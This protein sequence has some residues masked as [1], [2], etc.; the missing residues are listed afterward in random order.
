MTRSREAEI[1][2]LGAATDAD[3]AWSCHVWRKRN[4]A[5][6]NFFFLK[7]FPFH[8]KNLCSP[9]QLLVCRVLQF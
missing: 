1:L 4:V 7:F 6:M 3:L 2:E 5:G 8:L 9:G